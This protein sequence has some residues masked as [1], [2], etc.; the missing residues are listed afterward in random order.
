MKIV[1]QFDLVCL[2]LNND[3][4]FESRHFL[5]LLENILD[6]FFD[7]SMN[8]SFNDDDDSSNFN[9]FDFRASSNF[10]FDRWN[11]NFRINRDENQWISILI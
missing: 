7:D 6:E 8:D 3:C 2:N 10:T 11:E 1:F 5:E 9:S 4:A